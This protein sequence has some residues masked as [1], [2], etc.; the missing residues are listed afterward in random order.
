MS[1]NNCN[2]SYGS[3]SSYSHPYVH[4]QNAHAY[5]HGYPSY[6]PALS[7]P[8]YG[9]YSAPRYCGPSYASPSYASPSYGVPNV[10]SIIKTSP[11]TTDDNVC[12]LNSYD[13]L[14]L[15]TGTSDHLTI[16]GDKTNKKVTFALKQ[17]AF[18]VAGDDLT[19]GLA[20]APN[21]K[22]TSGIVTLP[23]TGATPVTPNEET[24]VCAATLADAT[25]GTLNSRVLL[26]PLSEKPPTGT[27]GAITVTVANGSFKINS[28]QASDDRTYQWLLLN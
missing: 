12:A 7:Y 24:V 26:T 17:V 23:G 21:A 6:H 2:H 25:A 4:H 13:T 20:L 18:N 8:G 11:D 5:N 19:A 15:E 27:P 3:K 14:C 28:D 9:G 10:F 16:T 22:R 1:Y